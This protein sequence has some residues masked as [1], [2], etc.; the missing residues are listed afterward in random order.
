MLADNSGPIMLELWRES[1]VTIFRFLQVLNNKD[2]DVIIIKLHYF[3]TRN[4]YEGIGRVIP[5][6]RMITGNIRTEVESDSY[7]DPTPMLHPDLYVEDFNALS[8]KTPFQ[9]NLAGY[10]ANVSDEYTSANGN[11]VK[12]F[13]LLEQA[14]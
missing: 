12:T 3:T 10:I 5:P 2:E 1:A 6:M 7:I 14:H 4:M 13:H 9:I 8:T 11:P